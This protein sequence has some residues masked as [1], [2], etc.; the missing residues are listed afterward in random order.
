MTSVA[1]A[2]QGSHE[3]KVTLALIEKVFHFLRTSL[4]RPVE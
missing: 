4:A 1:P 3:C 2:L